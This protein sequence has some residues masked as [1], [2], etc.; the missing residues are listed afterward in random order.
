ML[1]QG[2]VKAFRQSL[3]FGMHLRDR[4][5]VQLGVRRFFLLDVRLVLVRRRQRLCRDGRGLHPD[6]GLA[7]DVHR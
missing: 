5:R 1:S 4:E 7:L 2:I 6:R 3:P